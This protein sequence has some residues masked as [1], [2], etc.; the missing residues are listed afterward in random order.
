[1]ISKESKPESDELQLP[2][3]NFKPTESFRTQWASQQLKGVY[4]PMISRLSNDFQRAEMLTVFNR[5]RAGCITLADKE[6]LLYGSNLYNEIIANGCFMHP[7]NYTPISKTYA[8]EVQHL[9]DG[10]N[11]Q[12]RV[13]ITNYSDHPNMDNLGRILGYPDCCIKFFEKYWTKMGYR[14]MVPCMEGIQYLELE[15]NTVISDYY[16]VCNILLKGMGVRAVPHLPCSLKCNHTNVFAHKFLKY[17]PDSS[18]RLLLELLRME[19]TYS[20]YHGYAEVKN[21]L[22]KNVFNSIPL[23]DK[24]EFTLKQLL[25]LKAKSDNGFVDTDSEM[26]AHNE[27][28]NFIAAPILSGNS[29]VL[30]LGCGDATL[31]H[32]IGSLYPGAMLEGVEIDRTVCEKAAKLGG[33]LLF[34]QDLN[35]FVF[36]GIYTLVM[37]ANQRI[38]E[39][40]GD[41]N[42][43]FFNNIRSSTKYLLIYDY[44]GED[45]VYPLNFSRIKHSRGIAASMAIYV[46]YKVN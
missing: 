10:E 3:Y 5:E 17:L 38:R 20:T 15:K 45:V 46:P 22:F 8:N 33:P 43:K 42:F 4:E 37:I 41:E 40:D 25:N 13:L 21:R 2:T 6:E 19:T 9:M 28:I 35:E 34:N 31:L 26:R 32:R 23:G 24:L 11:F 12:V 36:N 18:Y 27:I 14:D 39:M 44:T 16:E 29:R 1:M 7:L 30:D